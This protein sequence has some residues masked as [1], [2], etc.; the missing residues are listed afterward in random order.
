MQIS[1][2]F[3]FISFLLNFSFLRRICVYVC[4]C[5]CMCLSVCLSVYVCLS[6]CMSVY[7]YHCLLPSV[8][9]LPC[10]SQYSN[11]SFCHMLFLFSHAI[12]FFLSIFPSF[13]SFLIRLTTFSIYSNILHTECCLFCV[14]SLLQSSI[15]P[16]I[17]P[18][19]RPSIHPFIHPSIHS[20]IHPSIHPFIYPSIY[21]ILIIS[22]SSR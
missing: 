5:A 12:F 6:I 14:S 21:Y 1:K 8:F 13:P 10:L 2:N 16:S 11:V 19:V 20:S 22:A 3:L 7:V 17:H 18:S 15:H 9:F 4:V